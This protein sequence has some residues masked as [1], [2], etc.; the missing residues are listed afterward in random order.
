MAALLSL[1]RFQKREA[2][3]DW[4]PLKLPMMFASRLG[5]VWHRAVTSVT[6]T[7]HE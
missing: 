7:G 3:E 5:Q 1:A 6:D 2:E 4:P